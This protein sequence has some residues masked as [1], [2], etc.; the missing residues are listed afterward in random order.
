MAVG[1]ITGRFDPSR[2]RDARVTMTFG[3][4]TVLS[5]AAQLLQQRVQGSSGWGKG[6]RK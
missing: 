1:V 5:S 4:R 2:G 6:Q 3:V